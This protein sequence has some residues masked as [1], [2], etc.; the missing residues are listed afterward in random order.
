MGHLDPLAFGSRAFHSWHFTISKLD[1]RRSPLVLMENDV[2]QNMIISLSWIRHDVNQVKLTRGSFFSRSVR[3][4]T[5]KSLKLIRRPH[6]QIQWAIALRTSSTK[7]SNKNTI[8]FFWEYYYVVEPPQYLEK[9]GRDWYQ[10]S[11]E[12]VNGGCAMIVM[13]GHIVK[14]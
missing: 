9:R 1:F 4:R 10:L 5:Q 7:A 6:R 13:Y 8:M 3:E 2:E 11:S 14:I 12:S